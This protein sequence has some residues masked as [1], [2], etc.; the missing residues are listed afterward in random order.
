MCTICGILGEYNN[1]VAGISKAWS[2]QA[3][4]PGG[5]GATAPAGLPGHGPGPSGPS[6]WGVLSG[7]AFGDMDDTDHMD[8]THTIDEWREQLQAAECRAAL[9]KAALAA[10]HG[11]AAAGG[12]GAGCSIRPVPL[13]SPAPTDEEIR[14]MERRAAAAKAAMMAAR[15]GTGGECGSGVGLGGH[16]PSQPLGP[17]PI[18][19]QSG[20]TRPALLRPVVGKAKKPPPPLPPQAWTRQQD[21]QQNLANGH[22][23]GGHSGNGNDM[24]L[25][26]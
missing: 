25:L 14:E 26:G 22:R 4:G 18:P 5:G 19:S 17:P 24:T 13:G 15:H 20:G 11:V 2:V 23:V 6:A 12:C 1:I 3:P 9:A 7:G 21:R 10:Y 16:I 8:V